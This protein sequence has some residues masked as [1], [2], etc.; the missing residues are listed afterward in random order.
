LQWLNDN[1]VEEKS[2]WRTGLQVGFFLYVHIKLIAFSLGE[3]MIIS[4]GLKN[5]EEGQ[6]PIGV[7]IAIIEGKLVK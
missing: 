4:K 5:S 6:M 7:Q 3:I 2:K 1:I